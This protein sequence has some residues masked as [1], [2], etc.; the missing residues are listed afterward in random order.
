MKF[1]LNY[2]TRYIYKA[3]SNF[4]DTKEVTDCFVS[5]TRVAQLVRAFVL[6]TKGSR[7][8][9][10]HGYFFNLNFPYYIL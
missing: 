2:N 3:I 6:L 5:N 1:N 10:W 8:E 4:T 9:S 7:F